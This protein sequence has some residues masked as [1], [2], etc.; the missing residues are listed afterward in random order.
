MIT[1]E[2]Y[3]EY[4]REDALDRRAA[5]AAA[6]DDGTC[7]DGKLERASRAYAWLRER[8][9]VQPFRLVITPGTPTDVPGGTPVALSLDMTDVQSDTFTLA[10]V[11][12]K[13]FA[14]PDGPYTWSEDSAGAVIS[15]AVSDD[16]SS[17]VATAVAPGVATLTV[18]DPTGLTGTEA[19]TVTPGPVA[20]I[21]IV[22][23]TP[24]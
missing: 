3:A 4:V 17:V 11:D 7:W 10:P 18:T 9:T 15:L 8:P 20:S 6:G 22:A 16:T 12:A 14:V 19:V 5:L 23:G 13:G 2:Q 1:P 21:S 24:A